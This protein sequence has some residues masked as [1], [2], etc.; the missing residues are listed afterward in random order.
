MRVEAVS[1]CDMDK[2]FTFEL[3]Q[4]GIMVASV[5]SVVEEHALD[6]IAHYALMYGQD[7]P[8][9][10]RGPVIQDETE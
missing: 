8:C 4:D 10:I 1:D 5:S 7:G 6:E 3:W 2:D 9:E